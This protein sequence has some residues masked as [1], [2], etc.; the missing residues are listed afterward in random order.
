MKKLIAIIKN[1]KVQT[2]VMG[3]ACVMIFTFIFYSMFLWAVPEEPVI[4]QQ[5]EIIQ[6]QER[7]KMFA[8]QEKRRKYEEIA[9]KKRA[10]KHQ[11]DMEQLYNELYPEEK[12]CEEVKQAFGVPEHQEEYSLSSNCEDFNKKFD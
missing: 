7:E 9:A 2:T 6:Q 3:S 11:A 12:Y 5:E 4:E 1:Q 10:E 8:E